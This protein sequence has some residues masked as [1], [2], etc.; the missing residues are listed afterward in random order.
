M[1]Q[2]ATCPCHLPLAARLERANNPPDRATALIAMH[3]I[4]HHGITLRCACMHSTPTPHMTWLRWL[5]GLTID[6]HSHAHREK[7]NPATVELASSTAAYMEHYY[8][9]RPRRSRIRPSLRSYEFG[10]VIGQG[11]FGVVHIARE[12]G[13]VVAVKQLRKVE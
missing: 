9:H 10:R 8:S 2:P 4:R 11:A 12:G 5:T 7:G 6:G 13:R 3:C 1:F